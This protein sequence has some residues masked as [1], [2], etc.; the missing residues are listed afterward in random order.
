MKEKF[1]GIA[2]NMNGI[3]AELR[4]DN[5]LMI[6]GSKWAEIDPSGYDNSAISILNVQIEKYKRLKRSLINEVITDK[7]KV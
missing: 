5:I 7:R 3:V 6:V 4:A 2:E 1:K